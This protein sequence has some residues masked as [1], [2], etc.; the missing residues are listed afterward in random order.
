MSARV[1][2]SPFPRGLPSCVLPALR[3]AP[4]AASLD[5]FGLRHADEESTQQQQALPA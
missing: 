3:A 4:P 5:L 1:G 2:H